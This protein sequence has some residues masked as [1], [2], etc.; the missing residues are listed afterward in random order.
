MNGLMR[1]G[2]GDLLSTLPDAV[3]KAHW[4]FR[5]IILLGAFQSV[6][7]AAFLVQELSLGGW[8]AWQSEISI[9]E[10][11]CCTFQL[12]QVEFKKLFTAIDESVREI[13]LQRQA[14]G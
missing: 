4:S 5:D 11:D 8:S 2:W 10:I 1:E 7:H 6:Y 3:A 13:I 12:Y 14:G 9:R